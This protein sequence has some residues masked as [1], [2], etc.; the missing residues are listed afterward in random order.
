[1]EKIKYLNYAAWT[2]LVL[3]FIGAIYLWK[4]LTWAW[5]EVGVAVIFALLLQAVIIAGALL[6]FCDMA[7]NIN[8]IKNKMVGDLPEAAAESDVE[9]VKREEF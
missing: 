2:Y 8:A 3:S 4:P 1:M 9:I 7:S 6:V 5:E